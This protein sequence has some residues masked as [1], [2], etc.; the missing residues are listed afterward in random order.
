MLLL[1][2]Y[3]H[4]RLCGAIRAE[5]T[6]A[7]TTGLVNAESRDWD[8]ALIGVLGYP[9]AIFPEIAQPG[10]ELGGL[11]PQMREAVGFDCLVVLPATHD[12]GSAV[13]AV[14]STAEDT[15]YIS[16]GTWSLLGIERA[17]PDCSPE[18]MGLNFTNEGGYPLRYRYLRNIMGLWMIQSISKELDGKYSF[19]ELCDMA[20]KSD[21]ASIVDC[22]DLRFYAPESMIRTIREVCAESGQREPS[23]PGE[24]AAVI[25]NS[26]ARCYRDTIAALEQI[27]GKRFDRIHV[28]GGGSNADYLNQLTAQATGKP[29]YAGPAEATAIGNLTAQMI[30]AGELPDLRA[31]RACIGRSFEVREFR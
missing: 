29:V 13:L 17:H 5:Y 26:L 7:T 23:E 9:R 27:T 30:A 18:S 25:Y 24:L 19:S 10:T 8:D 28:M 1:P 15:L 3:L 22:N 16:S 20:S 4:Y 21:I 11:T 2:D 12:T 31:A 14:P 6:N